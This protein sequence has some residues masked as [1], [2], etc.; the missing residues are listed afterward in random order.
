VNENIMLREPMEQMQNPFYKGFFV[1]E[2]LVTMGFRCVGKNVKIAKSCTIVGLENISI[3]CN[4]Q[5]DEN[6]FIAANKGSLDIG[7]H[8]HIGGGSH[9]NSTGGIKLAD[10]CGLSQ[11]VKIYSV[12]D[13]YTGESLTNVT[14][15]EK[16]KKLT[17][18]PVNMERHVLIGT[19]S[20][21]LPG[22]TIGMGS[23]VGALSLVTMSLDEWGVYFGTPAKRINARSKKM[24]EYEE[25]IKAEK[26]SNL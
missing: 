6:V 14:V 4:V 9:L 25:K 19:G 8:V 11:G 26:N 24:V 13:D 5:I 18:L 16:Y 3:G 20:V 2:E 1:S 22:V 23:A 17:I 12:S 7:N 10:F 21:V 15:P